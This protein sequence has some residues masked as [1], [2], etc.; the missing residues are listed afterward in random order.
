MYVSET[1]ENLHLL[2]ISRY[3]VVFKLH[4]TKKE[5]ETKDEQN[6]K[7]NERWTESKF[8]RLVFSALRKVSGTCRVD[9]AIDY[10]RDVVCKCFAFVFFVFHGAT[11]NMVAIVSKCVTIMLKVYSSRGFSIKN[12][13]LCDQRSTMKDLCLC[14][15]GHFV[16]TPSLLNKYYRSS[17]YCNTQSTNPSLRIFGDRE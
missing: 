13:I 15:S 5:E 10:K 9:L 12:I 8:S 7:R 11:K 4:V 6:W 2:K 3:T 17:W 1:C 14:I 16:P